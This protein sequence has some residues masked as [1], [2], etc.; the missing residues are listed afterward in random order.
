MDETLLSLACVGPK[1]QT[2]CIARGR[3]ATLTLKGA[4]AQRCIKAKFNKLNSF[5][6]ARPTFGAEN[7]GLGKFFKVALEILYFETMNHAL[8]VR[9]MP[10]QKLPLAVCWGIKPKSTLALKA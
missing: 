7:T 2:V 5:A 9:T 3:V 10:H 4:R 6:Q 1:V 8:V